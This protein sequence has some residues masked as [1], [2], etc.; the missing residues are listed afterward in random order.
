M[1]AD[2]PTPRNTK[3]KNEIEGAHVIIFQEIEDVKESPK[4]VEPKQPEKY[5]VF[6]DI[7]DAQRLYSNKLDVQYIQ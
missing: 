1:G 2:E 6:A 5:S 4:D 3:S 7:R